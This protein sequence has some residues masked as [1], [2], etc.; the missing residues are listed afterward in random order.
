MQ[1]ICKRAL[2]FRHPGSIKKIHRVAPSA[3]VQEAPDWVRDTSGFQTA[4]RDGSIREVVFKELDA[5]VE[6]PSAAD[7]DADAKDKTVKDATKS[8]T[9]K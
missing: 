4:K 3:N 6:K 2:A 9:T 5:P 1:V 8:K 7:L